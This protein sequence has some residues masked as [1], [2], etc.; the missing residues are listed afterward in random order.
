MANKQ[1]K[2]LSALFCKLGWH[3]QLGV[4][5]AEYVRCYACGKDYDGNLNKFVEHDVFLNSKFYQP[6]KA[7]YEASDDYKKIQEEVN[8]L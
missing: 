5:V 1:S 8:N 4:T 7:K 2:W 3:K 6:L